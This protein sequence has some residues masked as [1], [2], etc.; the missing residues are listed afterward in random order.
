MEPQLDAFTSALIR[1]LAAFWEK[2]LGFMPNL[3][4]TFLVLIM[5]LFLAKFSK[6]VVERLLALFRFEALVQ[7]TG[8]ESYIAASGYKVTFSDLIS[9]T[10][11]WLVILMTIT[12]IAD[13][14]HLEI[15]SDLF[16][17]IV[18]YLP[19]VIL[20][21]II[22][23]FG[24]IFS[25]IVNRYVFNTMKERAMD[26]ALTLGIVAEIIV[27]VFV[28]FL[29]LEQLQINTVLLLIVLCA[30]FAFLAL[31]GGIAFG[32]AGQKLAGEMLEKLRSKVERGID[33]E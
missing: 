1:A 9:G 3:L 4:A 27:Q 13:L 32:F 20:A 11:Y 16:E 5:G 18:I 22:L 6:I 15:I 30:T 33:E 2:I 17:R 12:S 14:L 7:K 10:I 28:W 25:R 29:A 23:I 24:T 31:A 19:N 21:V 8:L 26:L